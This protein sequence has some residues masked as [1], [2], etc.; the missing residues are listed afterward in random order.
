MASVLP[1][2][3]VIPFAGSSTSDLLYDGWLVCN[4]Q[5]LDP[6]DPE[7]TPLFDVI[8]TAFGGSGNTS[9]NLPDLQGLFVRG[10]DEGSGHD[11]D[12]ATR[13]A[14][15]AGGATGDKVGSVQDYETKSPANKFT[16]DIPHLP[17]DNHKG[18]YGS[19]IG[20]RYA[21]W[22]GG[23]IAVTVG[24]GDAES[25]PVNIYVNYLIKFADYPTSPGIP[26]GALVAVAGSTSPGSQYTL[27][28]GRQLST[29]DH[30]NRD[31]YRAIGTANGGD[32]IPY[33]HLPDC[34][35]RFL[36]GVSNSTN[37][38]PDKNS[39]TPPQTT[40]N[41]GNNV[42]SVQ[43]FATGIPNKDFAVTIPNLP[44]DDSKID[45]ILGRSTSRKNGD[46][47]R[48]NLASGG[49]DPE[50]RPVNV[51]VDWYIRTI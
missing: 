27:C 20:D 37:R 22:N 9:F 47:V 49:G 42:G 31:I 19:L 10:A 1:I 4:G 17:D 3:A 13:F 28:D 14:L 50:T 7:Y 48:I 38:D 51:Y 16:A 29:K 34:R 18:N 46:A 40:G 36:R 2:G 6:K 12:A 44:N 41:V 39:R 43:G 23:S 25:R 45:H 24:G 5:S 21:D 33:F 30:T 8:G 11:L 15:T 26:I 32:G 35:G